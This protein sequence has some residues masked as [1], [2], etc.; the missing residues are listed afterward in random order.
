MRLLVAAVLASC[1]MALLTP[2]ASAD[3]QDCPPLCDRIPRSAWIAPLSIP[4]YDVYRWPELSAVSVTAVAPRFRFEETCA[5]RAA[6]ADDPRS[7]AVA[8]RAAVTSPDRQWHL[9]AQIL[10]WRGET[11]RG[12]QLATAVFDEA[13]AALRNCQ[14]TAPAVSPSI[15][16]AGPA[17]MAAVLSTPDRSV[18]HQYLVVDPRNSTVTELALWSSAQPS[19]P[20]RP[21]PDAFVLDALAAPLCTAYIASCR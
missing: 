1:G 17:R 9:Q 16:T 5:A 19:V 14:I 11:W 20:W 18:L 10:H 7:W 15:T 12:G 2:V 6:D 4:L 8:A 13:V 21:V 3:P